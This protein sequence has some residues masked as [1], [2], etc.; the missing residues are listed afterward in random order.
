MDW[1]SAK[2]ESG[3]RRL[4]PA[5]AWAGM[6]LLVLAP[7]QSHSEDNG[8]DPLIVSQDHSWPPFAYRDGNGEPQGLLV[9]LWEVLAGHMGR[10]VEF[11]LVDWPETLLAV[12]TG[13]ADVHG[14]LFPSNERAEFFDF[15]DELTL[16]SAYLFVAAD[17]LVMDVE[18]LRGERIGVTAGSYELEFLRERFPFLEVRSYRN[19]EEMVLAA[20]AGEV[21]AF[22]AD[23]PVGMYLLD[24]HGSQTDF[25]LLERLYTQH[26]VAAVKKGNR[27]LL[28][29]VNNALQL[30]SEEDMRRITQRWMR[31]ERI[32]VLPAW[33]W[34]TL[35]GSVLLALLAAYSFALLLQR[36]QLVGMV[37]QRTHALS[38]SERRYRDLFHRSPEAYLILEGGVVTDCN[39]AAVRLMRTRKDQLI[40]AVP[41]LLSP[42]YQPDGSL[43]VDAAAR[44]IRSAKIEGSARFEWLLRR[45]DGEDLWVEISLAAIPDGLSSSAFLVAWH[46]ITERKLAEDALNEN[47]RRYD[48]LGHQSRTFLWEVDS[49]GLFTYVSAAVQ[50]VLGYQPDDLVGKL[51]YFDICPEQDRESM[52]ELG[53]DVAEQ[54]DSLVNLENRIV[55]KDG[56][57]ITVMTSGVPLYDR[58]GDL[59]GFRGS[60]T[61]ITDRKAME[62]QLRQ[63]KE[64][65][66]AANVAKSEFP[67][68]MSHEIRTPM[69]GVIG[70]TSLLLDTEL[71]DTQRSYA[72]TVRTSSES[73]LGLL[74]D[75]LDLSKIEAR[76]ME[77]EAVDFDLSHVI[78]DSAASL[79]V[80]AREKGLKLSYVVDEDVPMQLHGDPVRL[81]QVINN[82]AGNAVKFT[83]EGEVSIRV[84]LFE[85][86]GE[87]IELHFSISDTG[88]GIPESKLRQIFDKFS[89]VDASTTRKFGGTGLGLAISKELVEMMEGDIGVESHEGEGSVFWFSVRL[90]HPVN[91][92]TERKLAERRVLAGASGSKPGKRAISGAGR[93]H[94]LLVED[95]P[96]NQEVAAGALRQL[97]FNVDVASSGKAGVISY[98][99]TPYD[100]ILMDVQMPEMDGLEATRRI[101][102]WERSRKAAKAVPIVAL[103]AHA[104]QGDRERCIEAGM[105]DHV[106]KPVSTTALR[107]ALA[108]WLPIE[109]I[110]APQPAPPAAA[111][112]QDRVFDLAH[113]LQ[114]LRGDEALASSIA[115]VFLSDIPD[116]LSLLSKRIEGGDYKQAANLAHMIRGAAINVSGQR[117]GEVAGQLEEAL[118][119]DETNI[120]RTAHRELR[121][122]FDELRSAIERS[123]LI[124]SA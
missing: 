90:G 32:E 101:R 77:L 69:N 123:E 57:V 60:D 124:Q 22:V 83:Q 64:S 3:A 97:G 86:T 80:R 54:R 23:Y 50:S 109:E 91:P 51:H 71:T 52:V 119:A 9:E 61:D 18:G 43:S 93:F 120:I 28:D 121:V 12:R 100:L 111:S 15:S 10:S 89:Q 46:D 26:L 24:R 11:R 112:A 20:I 8:E 7:V 105:N 2:I 108:R 95:N 117:L 38:E 48:Q 72:E 19:N 56:R 36:R 42:K 114:R 34:S 104:M 116:Q 99:E 67:A 82:L 122:A 16:L 21:R 102:D 13:Q 63:A 14:G 66:E 1:L 62:V 110:D 29:E 113:F 65:A 84:S 118:R 59:V 37:E 107:V 79:D 106:P 70:M 41:H 81:C 47:Q 94:I 30:L 75:I 35:V 74:N 33:F 115:A 76:K 27:E 103:T 25:R 68:N 5:F 40:G 85:K 55:G 92:T 78:D 17:S 58:S 4:L 45:F 49:A 87:H 96:T 88:I 31:S 39:E 98:Q 73:L 6:G 53:M 44:Y